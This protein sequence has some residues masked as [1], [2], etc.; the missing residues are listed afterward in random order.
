MLIAMLRNSPLAALVMLGWS[1][2]CLSTVVRTNQPC[3]KGGAMYGEL[4]AL[5]QVLAGNYVTRLFICMLGTTI[6][7]NAVQVLGSQW[8]TQEYS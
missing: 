2:S 7:L 4:L 8:H 6:K 3:T 5:H 1:C